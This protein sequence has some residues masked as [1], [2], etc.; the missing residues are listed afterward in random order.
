MKHVLNIKNNHFSIMFPTL[1]MHCCPFEGRH[2]VK[3]DS[4]YEIPCYGIMPPPNV[5]REVYCFPSLPPNFPLWWVACHIMCLPPIVF[6]EVAIL[7]SS[8][9]TY[10]QLWQAFHIIQKVFES[11]LQNRFH[12]SVCNTSFG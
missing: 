1:G 8:S 4:L 7:F 12:L 10:F 3:F 2:K 9:P 6:E 5:T 11:I